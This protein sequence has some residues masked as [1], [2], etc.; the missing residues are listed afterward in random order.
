[1][2]RNFC[3]PEF[4]AIGFYLRLEKVAPGLNPSREDLLENRPAEELVTAGHVL[5]ARA[6]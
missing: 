4:P 6:E 5:K 1:M 3:N 2:D